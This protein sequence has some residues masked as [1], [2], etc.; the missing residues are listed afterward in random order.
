MA[1][2]GVRG[3]LFRPASSAYDK[4]PTFRAWDSGL[5]F[6]PASSA[7][8]VHTVLVRDSGILCVLKVSGSHMSRPVWKKPKKVRSVGGFRAYRMRR[9]KLPHRG[10]TRTLSAKDVTGDHK[11][12]VHNATQLLTI[13]GVTPAALLAVN[14]WRAAKPVLREWALQRG[15][16]QPFN[17]C[18]G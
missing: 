9:G 14:C 17:G 10:Y 12:S 13:H 15:I 1:V 7:F 3:L 4:V 11:R 5:F 8:D 6:R 16:S 18:T 2:V